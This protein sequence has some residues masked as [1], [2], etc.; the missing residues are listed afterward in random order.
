MATLRIVLL[1]AAMLCFALATL[2]PE[3]V[4]PIRINLIAGGLFCWSLT[5]A[6]FL[7]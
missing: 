6:P 5:Q 3:K 1:V 2:G 4:G 7:K